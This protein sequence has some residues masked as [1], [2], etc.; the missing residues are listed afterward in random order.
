MSV[1]SYFL[2]LLF[3]FLFIPCF[4]STVCSAFLINIIV[5]YYHI[6][7]I[8][9]LLHLCLCLLFLYNWLWALKTFHIKITKP[10]IPT[11]TLAFMFSTQYKITLRNFWN[12][13]MEH[14]SYCVDYCKT[15]PS[16]RP[17]PDYQLGT[18]GTC[19]GASKLRD[20]CVPHQNK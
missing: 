13:I 18:A 15:H 16:P 6:F 1:T 7:N 17:V 4:T 3:S 10:F 19:L 2:H 14:S 8:K 11:C 20:S 12:A 9:H 5:C